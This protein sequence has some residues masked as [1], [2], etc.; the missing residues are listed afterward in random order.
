[1]SRVG[2]PVAVPEG[3]EV[4]MVDACWLQRASSVR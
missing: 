4:T 2:V 3:V 1:M